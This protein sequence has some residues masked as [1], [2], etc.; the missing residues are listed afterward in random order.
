MERRLS[1]ATALMSLVLWSGLAQAQVTTA[2]VG[3]LVTDDTGAVLPGAT[4]ALTHQETGTVLTAV[5]NERGEFTLSF[6]PIGRYTLAVTLTG[7]GDHRQ[8][9]FQ[10]SA[11][12]SV[13][14]PIALRVGGVADVVNVSAAAPLINRANA[15][16][17]EI[18]RAQQLVE[19]PLGQRNWARALELDTSAVLA[20][21][22]G[23]AMN[24]LPPAA[25]SLTVDGVNGSGDAELPSVTVYQGFN[26]INGVTTEA[27]EEISMSKGIA[28]AEYGGTM[29]GNVNIITRAGTNRF[30]GSL[31]ENHQRDEFDASN[32]FVSLTPDKE[33]N[34]FGGSFG[35]PIRRDRL[36]FFGA[37]EGVRSAQQKVLTGTVPTPEWRR[38]ALARNQ[39]YAPLFA[40]FPDPTQPYAAGAITG[41]A[42]VIRPDARNDNHLTLRSDVN[43]TGTKRLSARYSAGRPERSDGRLPEKNPRISSG[44]QDSASVSLVHAAAGWV[45]ETRAGL[46]RT[47]ID[48]VDQL[49]VLGHPVVSVQGLDTQGGE[50]FQKDGVLFSLD[51]VLATQR[52]RHALK[53]GFNLLHSRT[54]RANFQTTSFQYSSLDDFYANIPSSSSFT[55]GLDDFRLNVSQF[56]GFVQ[57][58]VNLGP[59]LVVNLGVRYDYF[60]VPEERDGRLFNRA[61][62]Y[63]TG[64]LRPPD[65]LYKADWNNI[66]PRV[67]FA[68][69][70][71]TRTVVRGGV[72]MFVNPH[73]LFGG[74]T[75]VV[76]NGADQQFRVQRSR[77]DAV[78]LGL[79]YPM[80]AAQVEA[81]LQ[82][83]AALWGT[84]SINPNRPNP[85]ST[86]WSLI[87]E[88]ELWSTYGVEVGYVGNISDNLTTLRRINQPDRLTGVRPFAG[89]AEFR[90][91]DGANSGSYHSL[92]MK[93]RR[94]FANRIA[95]GASYTLGEG[96]SYGDSDLEL[97]NALQ[98]SFDAAAEKGPSKWDVR[99]RFA[100]HFLYE[101]PPIGGHALVRQLLGGWQA[102]GI[103]KARSGEP[104]NITDGSSSRAS[105]RPDYVGGEMVLSDWRDTLVYFNRAAFARVPIERASGAQVRPGTLGWNAARG[106][107]AVNVD[108][109]LARNVRVSDLRF[110]IRV[111]MF[112]ATN[113]K[114]YGSPSTSINN[115]QFGRISSVSTRTMQVGARFS[116]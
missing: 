106:P 72:G 60:T 42:T 68:W 8:T 36:F 35:G 95:F 41:R 91:W 79:R 21:Q 65:E 82:G 89:F 23:V 105:S 114:N 47:R 25:L 100:A 61:D 109:G 27:I 45:A 52:G 66:S 78:L 7:F 3:G 92:Q 69:T 5:T 11:G 26:T 70:P 20:G 12:Q 102:S 4:I 77:Q 48:R 34:Q 31:F 55:F 80:D 19:L 67:G 38:E 40:L 103:L 33:F 116:F 13:R 18:V 97:V 104:L 62:P 9:G 29:S 63:G 15:Q 10:L 57:D 115:A 111:D 46:N 84:A 16:Q 73:P 44:V 86:Q 94:R 71:A 76:L 110:Q 24:G 107:G 17:Q 2:T 93:L 6:V 28:S 112:N 58:D 43:L 64:P 96:V 51:E 14:L 56:G 99:H 90:Y 75:D 49:Y 74:P 85:Y 32:P 88:Q 53:V 54:G 98:D 113:A 87:A 22:N 81:L 108:L 1:C 59:R 37:Y 30:H 39:I 83:P 101:I 50:F